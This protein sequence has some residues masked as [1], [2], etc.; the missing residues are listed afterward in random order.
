MSK[1]VLII[2][3]NMTFDILGKVRQRKSVSRSF[4]TPSVYLYRA[5]LFGRILRQKIRMK[6]S[7][8]WV[9]VYNEDIKWGAEH[10]LWGMGIYEKLENG[11][12]YASDR[13]PRHFPSDTGVSFS[14]P[15]C[16]LL[17]TPKNTVLGKEKTVLSLLIF[18]YLL[19]H[20]VLREIKTLPPQCSWF[21]CYLRCFSVSTEAKCS[22]TELVWASIPK[23]LES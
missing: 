17:L 14:H 4:C 10:V 11:I 20:I 3:C 8:L 6:F 7:V 15:P 18:F 13:L 1:T 16:D 12:R 22:I 21:L 5:I 23:Q 2:L 9:H 19:T